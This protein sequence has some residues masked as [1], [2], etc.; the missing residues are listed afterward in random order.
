MRGRAYRPVISDSLEDRALLSGAAV[1][2][3]GPAYLSHKTLDK[4]VGHTLLA[5]R[6]FVKDSAPTHP[7]SDEHLRE[8][9]SNVAVMIPYGKVDGLGI[10][11]NDII[12]RLED[13]IRARTPRAIRTAAT[14]VVAA[15]LE[16]VAARVQA[17]DVVVY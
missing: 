10:K 6:I 5:F 14:E 17:G 13:E 2:P 1:R 7:Y 3:H 4:V 16:T 8:S 15:T 12:D 11:I 9:I